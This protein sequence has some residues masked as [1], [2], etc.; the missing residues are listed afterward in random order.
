MELYRH[1]Q[2]MISEFTHLGA[3]QRR[4]LAW[5][6]SGVVLAEA[7]Q[8]S[9]VADALASSYGGRVGALT[10]RLS[11]FLSNPRIKDEALSGGWVRWVAQVY[12]GE[13]WV[14]LVDETK[15]GEHLSVMMVGLAYEGRA[16]P[17]VWRCYT[18]GDYPSEGQVGMILDL[19]GRLRQWVPP[20]IGLTV[21]AD[22]GLGTS[23]ALIRGLTQ[24][25]V[26]F[27]LRVQGQTRVR[28]PNGRVCALAS[29][30]QPG[31][32]WSGHAEVFKKAGW[33]TLH[34]HLLWRKGQAAPWCL[35]SNSPHTQPE[36]YARRAW[37]E[38]SF[39]DLKRFGWHWNASQVWRPAHAHRLLF[40]LALTYTWVL[41]QAAR[42]T[43]DQTPSPSRSHPR[44][45]L[46]RRGLRWIRQHL[47]RFFCAPLYAYL[48]FLSRTPPDH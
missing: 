42:F 5:W 28:L 6:C 9:K 41:S 43:P 48:C 38:H 46:F 12:E 19:V 15:L 3:W 47:V 23:P 27:V 45:S 40:I 7:C 21:Q 10:K 22:R 29:L 14:I 18:P 32:S 33:L 1:F 37:H 36:Y 39:R 25:G 11:R 31:Q 16:I 34:V 24:M 26:G 35:V 44:D 20:T 17:L 4:G 30:I 8:I 13:S 2:Q